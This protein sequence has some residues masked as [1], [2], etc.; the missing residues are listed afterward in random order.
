MLPNAKTMVGIAGT[1]GPPGRGV[2]VRLQLPGR[3]SGDRLQGQYVPR[4]EVIRLVP[5]EQMTSL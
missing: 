3:H 1:V 5:A 2:L 4:V